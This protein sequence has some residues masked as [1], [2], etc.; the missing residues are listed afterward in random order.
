MSGAG[1]PTSDTDC[2]SLLADLDAG[3]PCMSE[4]AE[5]I[6]L[7]IVERD[8]A[9]TPR[10]EAPASPTER[11]LDLLDAVMRAGGIVKTAASLPDK[12]AHL[13]LLTDALNR[14][15][16]ILT[17]G[18]NGAP[19]A[20]ED[21]RHP[22]PASLLDDSN[23]EAMEWITKNAMA[24][25]RDNGDMDYSL[26][27]MIAAY[28]AGKAAAVTPSAPT[29]QRCGGE[30]SGWACQECGAPFTENDVGALI[31]D[32]LAAP[33]AWMFRV[34]GKWEMSIIDPRERLKLA[35]E[36]VVAVPI[37]A[38]PTA[39]FA[40]KAKHLLSLAEEAEDK[41]LVG[42]EGCIWPVEALRAAY[43][44]LPFVMTI[45]IGGEDA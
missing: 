9:L 24:I 18:L 15:D 43:A 29:C 35:P 12:A 23:T 2:V 19:K 14:A 37:S 45:T 1:N 42:D 34:D 28:K 11:E 31:F 41:T 17:E 22:L 39:D 5:T 20:R 30:V 36:D 16:A 38:Q 27:A 6:R 7:L 13:S 44:A 32:R 10:H 26:R 33:S 25:R 4:A 40:A 3:K 21:R 8:A